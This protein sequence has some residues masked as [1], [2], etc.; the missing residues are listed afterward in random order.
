MVIF[1]VT[2]ILLFSFA[3]NAGSVQI[4]AF[5]PGL[6]WMTY[7]FSGVLGLLRIFGREKEMEAYDLLLCSPAGRSA[8]YLGKVIAFT[9]LL[10]LAQLISLPLF[11]LFLDLNMG[12]A[13]LSL[14]GLF[15]LANLAFAGVGTLVAALGL[16]S[17]HGDTLLPVLLFPILTPALIAATRATSAIFASRPLGEWDFWLMLL[18]TYCTLFILAGSFIYDYISEQ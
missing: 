9:I 8:I 12:A 6:I 16:R 15:L 18:V 14:A 3:F 7:F 1:S 5:A 17:P 2:V 11:S 10:G 4:R 13:P